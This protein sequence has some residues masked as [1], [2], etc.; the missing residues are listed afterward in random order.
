MENNISKDLYGLATLFKDF[1]IT[2]FV[3]AAVLLFC[4]MFELSLCLFVGSILLFFGAH[5]LKGFGENNKEE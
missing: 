5:L 3:V 2:A 1:G 4:S